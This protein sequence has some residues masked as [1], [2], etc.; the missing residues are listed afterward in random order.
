M[1]KL[2][3][4]SN[5]DWFFVSHRLPLAVGAREDGFELHFAT[6]QYSQA[7]TRIHAEKIQTH[8]LA[9]SRSG[10]APHK[11]L[12]SFFSMLLLMCRLRPRL[13]HLITVKPVLYGG[14]AAKLLGIP[15]VL[16]ITGLGHAFTGNG[17]FKSIAR[18]I[19]RLLYR[20]VLSG[21][22]SHVIVQNPSD[23]M[24]ILQLAKIPKERITLIPGSGVDLSAYAPV[25]E[26][27]GPLTVVMAVRLL[28]DKGVMEY[29]DASSQIKS[30]FPEVRFILAGD[31]DPGNPSSLTEQDLDEIRKCGIVEL[32]GFQS[33]IAG[34]FARAHL[35]VLPS[36][37]EGLP[38]VLIEAAACGRA[39]VTTAT[40]GCQDAILPNESGLLVPPG[41]AGALAGAILR[42][43]Q[44]A[45]LR[46]RMGKKGRNLAEARYDIRQVVKAHLEIYRDSILRTA[47]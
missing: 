40:P 45:P 17:I 26:P 30:R 16:A 33:D 5:T 46:H 22:K 44:D 32:V 3:F 10:Y 38:K 34:L 8:T 31:L 29:L 11:E 36:Y 4:I 42:L 39:V 21:R 19:L 37:R 6:R 28:R 7:I 9:F 43:L 47:P 18:P 2:L 25:P 41:D 20:W 1:K 14:I 27:E 15:R 23:L 24:N 12:F 13:V 35:V